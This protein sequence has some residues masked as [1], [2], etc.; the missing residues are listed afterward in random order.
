[1]PSAKYE[2][3][4]VTQGAT[5]VPA[6]KKNGRS[7]QAPPRP[8]DFTGRLHEP[9]KNERPANGVM[10]THWCPAS[11]VEWEC[12]HCGAVFTRPE[13]KRGEPWRVTQAQEAVA[14][15]PAG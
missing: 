10:I 12:P 7:A 3:R 5:P 9:P 1:M 2:K 8:S 13:E 15:D 6:P 11:G 4:N 14:A